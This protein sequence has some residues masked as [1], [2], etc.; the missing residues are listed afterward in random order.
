[1][2]GV[3]GYF[4]LRKD[5]NQVTAQIKFGANEALSSLSQ[6]ADYPE[7]ARIAYSSDN[8]Y[9]AYVGI[10]LNVKVVDIQA[11]NLVAEFKNQNNASGDSAQALIF[12]S[13]NKSIL[14]CTKR[15]FL[16]VW[17][18]S[19]KAE[20]LK[21]NFATTVE[22]LEVTKDFK[23]A[24][25]LV[26]DA[27]KVWS[28]DTQKVE[29]EIKLKKN[30]VLDIAL[31]PDN[32]FIGGIDFGGKVHLWKFE[33]AEKVKELDYGVRGQVQFTHDSKYLIA[34]SPVL[35]KLIY[36]WNLST[37]DLVA[38]IEHQDEIQSIAVSDDSKYLVSSSDKEVRISEIETGA[39]AN[40]YLDVGKVRAVGISKGN[41]YLI[42]ADEAKHLK[43][44]NLETKKQV[45]DTDVG[46]SLKSLTLSSDQ[47][48]VYGVSLLN[49]LNL[50]KVA[51]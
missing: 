40:Y 42:T 44:I 28:F 23:K 15:G 31:S 3:V 19:T 51:P 50:W 34:S 9:L 17:D 36:V 16:Q 47:G 14:L 7:A 43:V 48:Y 24:V 33:T 39:L 2:L 20:V 49:E 12:M 25:V 27:I 45:I 21:N 46:K 6:Y 37:L 22:S 10:D 13:E 26:D 8:K 18:L 11:K 30:D 32:Q 38:E 41:R 5:P 4:L 29:R 35:S 1:V